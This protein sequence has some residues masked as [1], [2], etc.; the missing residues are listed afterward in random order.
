M[1]AFPHTVSVT[2]VRGK[3]RYA[4]LFDEPLSESQRIFF[5]YEEWRV[6]RFAR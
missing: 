6:T 4:T 1:P 5:E 3:Q 2:D